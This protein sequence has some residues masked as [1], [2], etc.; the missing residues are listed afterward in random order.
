MD[1]NNRELAVLVWAGIVL[2]LM[3]RNRQLRASLGSLARTTLQPV[4]L[5]PVLAFAGYVAGWCWAGDRVEAWNS[6]LINETIWWFL[7]TGFVLLF[8][9]LRVAQEDDFFTRT[10][11]R[12]L[13]VAIFAE[14]FIN[15]VVLPLWA[16][17]FLLPIVTFIA[18]MQVFVERK[19]EYGAVRK[20]ADNLSA[21]IG[22]S[23]FAYVL[24]SLITSPT[25]LEPLDGL[26]SLLLPIVLTLLSLPFIYVF[27]LWIAYDSAFRW[28]GFQAS[29]RRLARRAKWAL[30][31]RLR[32]RAR[33]V[34]RFDRRWQNQ[35]ARADTSEEADAVVDQFVNEERRIALRPRVD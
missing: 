25:Q 17:F 30:L 35:L 22:L 14:F 2:I 12:A 24:I 10:A 20:L 8:G 15:L 18:V 16:E 3:L 29:D 7:L 27:G 5:L 23:L 21:V 26:R 6:R 1:F 11:K 32:W 13:T 33:R 34:G 19:D 9:A 31:T 4:I 28:I